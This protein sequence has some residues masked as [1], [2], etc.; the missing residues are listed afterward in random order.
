[1][2]WTLTAGGLV[3]LTACMART[4]IKATPKPPPQQAVW[5]G[6]RSCMVQDFDAATD[7][8]EGAKNLGWVSV[9]ESS[10]GDE[11]TY[12]E[13]RKKICAMGGDGLSQ[14]AWVREVDD[15]RPHLKANAWVLPNA[16]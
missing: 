9:A 2:K 10:G 8:P 4:E 15:E 13:L 14:P 12:L 5:M 6:D 3:A 1:M 7:V 16:P 11:Q